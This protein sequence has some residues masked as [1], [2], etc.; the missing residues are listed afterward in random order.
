MRWAAAEDFVAAA[1]PIAV[2]SL[3]SCCFLCA[4]AFHYRRRQVA[5]AKAGGGAL[6]TTLGALEA[7]D[8]ASPAR[9]DG[10]DGFATPLAQRSPP[11]AQ[12]LHST[13]HGDGGATHA[14]VL[15]APM[16]TNR[17]LSAHESV[18][19][20]SP[21]GRVRPAT[22]IQVHDDLE[23]PYYTILIEGAPTH[24][25]VEAARLRRVQHE[26][27]MA[28]DEGPPPH[29]PPADGGWTHER[30]AELAA[31]VYET[32]ASDAEAADVLAA[33]WYDGYV[34]AAAAASQPQ[35]PPPQTPPAAYQDLD[36]MRTRPGPYA[37]A[38]FQ[39]LEGP[40]PQS[41]HAGHS[42]PPRR[43]P[44]PPEWVHSPRPATPRPAT[45]RPGSPRP[46]SPRAPEW[47]SSPPSGAW[48]GWSALPARPP[49][50][51]AGEVA[52]LNR[53]LSEPPLLPGLP[54]ASGP[55]AEPY[56]ETYRAPPPPPRGNPCSPAAS[57]AVA[58]TAAVDAPP[59]R[60]ECPSRRA[61]LDGPRSMSP[62]GT[63]PPVAY[64][65]SPMSPPP[66]PAPQPPSPPRQSPPPPPQQPYDPW[67][68]TG[69]RPHHAPPRS[70]SPRLPPEVA[71]GAHALSPRPPAC[72]TPR[73][74]PRPPPRAMFDPPEAAA[75]SPRRARSA[76]RAGHG[77]GRP[78]AADDDVGDLRAPFALPPTPPPAEWAD[79][80]MDR[81]SPGSIV[82]MNR[83]LLFPSAR[84]SARRG[85]LGSSQ[86]QRLAAPICSA[87]PVAQTTALTSPGV[88]RHRELE[89][90]PSHLVFH[91]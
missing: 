66:P 25:A 49:Q 17:M 19:Y 55:R 69:V 18:L 68:A 4:L 32:S 60:H 48:G 88:T 70:I 15:T 90:S 29:E 13:C 85:R 42:S 5:A 65:S 56:H 72:F 45:P 47:I 86:R 7:A 82:R 43:R 27:A 63:M 74:V 61:R 38:T 78:A 21:D 84:L 1:V 53:R 37:G 28:I 12:L 77:R 89:D 81:V 10:V 73:S 64:A 24:T 91:L 8:G 26:H 51:T 83:E 54:H 41:Y 20:T 22:V 14:E 3:L 23:A 9:G 79:D 46:G 80:S 6:D 35:T 62:G 16:T 76:G 31:T 57:A 30:Y 58:S 39:D 67:G 40:S 36:S 33:F 71:S 75:G 52:R 59:S 50:P 44:E 34:T 87:R 2:V 11:P